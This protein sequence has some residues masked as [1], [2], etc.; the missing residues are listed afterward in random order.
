MGLNFLEGLLVWLVQRVAHSAAFQPYLWPGSCAATV[1]KLLPFFREQSGR[2]MTTHGSI[3]RTQ[4]LHSLLCLY[5][6]AKCSDFAAKESKMPSLHR[7]IHQIGGQSA[8]L[9]VA[10]I[11]CEPHKGRNEIL[12]ATLWHLV[13]NLTDR[14]C[15]FNT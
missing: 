11:C 10:D 15:L 1:V 9:A 14:R 6:G 7:G 13:A 8:C 4:M 3:T 5:I 2:R 12:S